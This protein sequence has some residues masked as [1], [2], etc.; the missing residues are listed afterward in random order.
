[1]SVV[2]TLG[3]WILDNA[4]DSN[5]YCLITKGPFQGFVVHFSH[6][7]EPVI[8]FDSL[9]RFIAET[10]RIGEAGGNIDNL[11]KGIDHRRD[12]SD[13]AELLV[14]QN[15][16]DAIFLLCL[17]MTG[18]PIISTVAQESIAACEDFYAGEALA[19]WLNVEGMIKD[20]PIAEKLASNNNP[21]VSAPGKAAAISIIKRSNQR[22]N[23]NKMP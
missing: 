8:A 1:M 6:D 21:Q 22:N 14:E 19:H 3:L 10:R 2:A 7:P 4:E 20:L 11:E 18:R 5:P 23:S 13:I 12:I 17:Y 16:E 9:V 15:T